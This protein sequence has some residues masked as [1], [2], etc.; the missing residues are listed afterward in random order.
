VARVIRR[1]K[2]K[3][4]KGTRGDKN[5]QQ[6]LLHGHTPQVKIPGIS[7]YTDVVWEEKKKKKKKSLPESTVEAARNR[8]EEACFMPEEGKEKYGVM[9]DKKGGPSLRCFY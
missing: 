2:N 9:L 3:S 5:R 1:E 4:R 6:N 7:K 8:G